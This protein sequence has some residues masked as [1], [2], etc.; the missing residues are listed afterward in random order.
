[1][2][3]VYQKTNDV[4]DNEIIKADFCLESMKEMFYCLHTCVLLTCALLV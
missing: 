4:S 2:F 3:V 1:M